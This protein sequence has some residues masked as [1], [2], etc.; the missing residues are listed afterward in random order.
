MRSAARQ[1]NQQSAHKSPFI[2]RK[3]RDRQFSNLGEKRTNALGI[4]LP[5]SKSTK[6]SPAG[7]PVTGV[8][9]TRC[10]LLSNGALLGKS[11]IGNRAPAIHVV[12]RSCQCFV[13]PRSQ[14]CRDSRKPREYAKSSA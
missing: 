1:H 7:I 8:V 9:Q 2:I 5:L 10:N 11:Y 4:F 13:L 6:K 12:S 14:S 3:L